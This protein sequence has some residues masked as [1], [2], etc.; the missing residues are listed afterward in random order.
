[1]GDLRRTDAEGV[2]AKSPMRRGVTI[3]ANNGE[4]GQRQPL[5]G[6][7]DMNDAL[8]GIIKTEQCNAVLGRILHELIDHTAD[9]RR[10]RLSIAGRHVMIGDTKSE[11]GAGDL[12]ATFADLIEGMERAFMEEMPV[13]PKQRLAIFPRGD[14]MRIPDLVNDSAGGGTHHFHFVSRLPLTGLICTLT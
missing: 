4:P 2:S 3:A 5:C 11:I 7:R 13:N 6:D 14:G 8:P 9:I 1:M 12:R 10:D